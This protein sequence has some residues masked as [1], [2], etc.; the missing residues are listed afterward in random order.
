[1]VSEDS[2]SEIERF[3]AEEYPYS[4]GLCSDKPY[5]YVTNLPPCLKDNPD[6]PGM[7]SVMNLQVI[8]KIP[9]LLILSVPIH[10]LYSRIVMNVDPGSIGITNM[11][12]YIS[13]GLNPWKTR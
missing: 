12:L 3:L 11:C 2:G 4:Y 13:L 1:M 6:F 7:N 5:D 10:S 8:W 9:H